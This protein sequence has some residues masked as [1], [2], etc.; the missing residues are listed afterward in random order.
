MQRI[1]M[2]AERAYAAAPG[3]PR[4]VVI[5][6]GFLR[7]GDIAVIEANPAH[8]SA[9]YDADPIEVLRTVALAQGYELPEAS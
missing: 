6:I 9:V 1:S 2:F 3:L 7:K 5:D 8:E 4:G